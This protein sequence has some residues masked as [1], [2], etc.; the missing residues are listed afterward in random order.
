MKTRRS[1][2]LASLL[3]VGLL[4][5]G[6]G[7]VNTTDAQIAFP[8]RQCGCPAVT[9]TITFYDNATI[10]AGIGISSG[11]YTL[12]DGFSYINIFVEFEQNAADEEPVSLGV[13]FAF[14]A[15]G[16]QGSRRYFNFEQNFSGTADPQM[17]TLSGAGSWHGSPHNRSSYTARLPV[18]GPYVQVFPFN[19]EGKNR[20]FS[21]RAY[22][23]H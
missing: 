23:T 13:V 22:L 18:M 15:S 12:I 2:L 10:P 14:D 3:V 11:T 9:R 17:I 19:H 20:K 6:Q 8:P 21:I 1:R 5:L 7:H 4:V 16:L